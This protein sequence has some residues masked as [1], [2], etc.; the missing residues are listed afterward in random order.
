MTVQCEITARKS[1]NAAMG[2]F[3]RYLTLWVAV[4]IIAGIG[5]GHWM[6]Q[7]FQS[8]GQLEIAEINMPVALLIWLMIIPMLLKID[9]KALRNVGEHWRGISVTLFVNWGVKPFSMALLGWLFI[10]YLF[11]DWL[12]ENQIDSYIAG[13]ILLAAAPC[14]AMVVNATPNPQLF[15]E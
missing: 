2:V 8:I 14:T 10:G 11:R 6:P 15:A 3:E 1:A 9:L 12:P 5:L 7:F 13:L 4:C